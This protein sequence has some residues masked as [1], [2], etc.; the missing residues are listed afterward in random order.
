MA[1]TLNLTLCRISRT[2]MSATVS[3]AR[4]D[5]PKIIRAR[6][7]V[8]TMELLEWISDELVD[9]F[10]NVEE[11]EVR[12]LLENKKKCKIIIRKSVE[13]KL[14]LIKSPPRLN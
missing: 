2:S 8:K 11:T 4:A 1:L 13:K 10:E 12:P 6:S 9:V 5:S 14:T 7:L 3:L